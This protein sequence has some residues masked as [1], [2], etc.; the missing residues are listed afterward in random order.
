M[1]NSPKSDRNRRKS[2]SFRLPSSDADHEASPANGNEG[3]VVEELRRNF[4]QLTVLRTTAA[5][6]LLDEYK[7]KMSNQLAAA[8]KLIDSLKKENEELHRKNTA[9][10]S[11]KGRRLSDISSN[12]GLNDSKAG[13]P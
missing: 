11:V 6:K 9:A 8:E 7:K 2:V 5:E 3:K 13:E 10:D 1:P 12:S 4:H